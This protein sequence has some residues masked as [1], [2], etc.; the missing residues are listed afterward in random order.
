[1]V[2]ICAYCDLS[3]NSIPPISQHVQDTHYQKCTRCKRSILKHKLVDHNCSQVPERKS[4]V[5]IEVPSFSFH[6]ESDNHNEDGDHLEQKSSGDV[7]EQ[8]APDCTY[9]GRA[10]SNEFN[11][12]QHVQGAHCQCVS[13]RRDFG[14]KRSLFQHRRDAHDI[15]F[16]CEKCRRD[17]GSERSLQQHTTDYQH[18]YSCVSCRKLFDT[19]SALGQHSRDKHTRS[20]SRCGEC[21]K[22]FKTKRSLHQHIRATHR[23]T[24]SVA[25]SKCNKNFKTK[26]A[27]QQH[28]SAAHRV[29][30]SIKKRPSNT[31]K[32]K[33]LKK[34]FKKVWHAH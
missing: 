14:S 26:K 11:Y 28:N 18:T 6:H 24:T 34:F 15:E 20:Q 10:F 27:L 16:R 2:Y 29:T 4:T 23:Q 31:T 22:E 1:M 12:N 13:C 21:N 17:F 8:L 32:K 5:K 25:C 33:I 19:E 30:H 3:S 7:P 9:C